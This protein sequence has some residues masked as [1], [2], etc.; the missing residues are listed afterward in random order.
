MWQIFIEEKNEKE[1]NKYINRAKKII[2]GD[3]KLVIRKKQL[4]EIRSGKYYW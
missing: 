1:A 4:E 3:K 2:D